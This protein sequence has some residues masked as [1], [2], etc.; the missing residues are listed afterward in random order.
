MAFQAY[1]RTVVAKA[2]R[3]LG[4]L[5]RT[6]AYFDQDMVR[7]LEC[8]QG[9][10]HVE[11]GNVIWQPRPQQHVNALDKADRKSMCLFPGMEP[12]WLRA[13]VANRPMLKTCGHSDRLMTECVILCH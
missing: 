9:R 5:Q 3:I 12:A 1:V 11:Y 13:P 6:L 7:K 10:P 4:M 8:A 2:L